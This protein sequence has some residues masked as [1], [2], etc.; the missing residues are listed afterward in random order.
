MEELRIYASD[1]KPT[2]IALGQYGYIQ[3]FDPKVSSHTAT[4]TVSDTDG[5]GIRIIAHAIACRPATQ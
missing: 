1:F 5:D 3:Y 4:F 2:T